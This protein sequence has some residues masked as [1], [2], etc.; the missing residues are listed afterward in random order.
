MRKRVAE[1]ATHT[2][3]AVD[4]FAVLD[5]P[6]EWSAQFDDPLRLDPLLREPDADE[7][8]G[9]EVEIFASDPFDVELLRGFSDVSL[10]GPDVEAELPQ[11]GPPTAPWF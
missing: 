11:F 10:L 7:D 3:A 2:R 8:A 5:F 6:L 9:L 1:C 4:N